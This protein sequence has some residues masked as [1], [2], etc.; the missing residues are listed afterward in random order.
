MGTLERPH[1][2]HPQYIRGS[3][4]EVVAPAR[5]IEQRRCNGA[6][7]SV[8]LQ[9]QPLL[10]GR[11]RQR[12]VRAFQAI[13]IELAIPPIPQADRVWMAIGDA[14]Q[15]IH[16]LA[17]IAP[18]KH[19]GEAQ[20]HPDA[21]H[22]VDVGVRA[23]ERA[24]DAGPAWMRETQHRNA[25]FWLERAPGCDSTKARTVRLAKIGHHHRHAEAAFFELPCQQGLLDLHPADAEMRVFAREHR[26]IREPD[27][28][29]LGQSLGTR[30]LRW[31]HQ[32]AS[33]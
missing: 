9:H 32:N 16:H 12:Q 2:S 33:G 31:L 4:R 21:T 3:L 28:T 29:N 25:G 5:R 11:L 20:L 26:Q 18:G 10:L 30:S 22:V 23:L 15:A 27:E 7:A 24:P 14:C 1:R 17:P 8:I 6:R 13:L 19:R